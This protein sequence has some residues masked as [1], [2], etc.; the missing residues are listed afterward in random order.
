[1]MDLSSLLVL[2]IG[3]LRPLVDLEMVSMSDYLF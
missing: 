2:Q 3:A 1:M